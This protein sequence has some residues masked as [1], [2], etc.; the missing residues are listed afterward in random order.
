MTNLI[1][2]GNYLL[3][4]LVFLLSKD[5]LLYGALERS[6]HS[7][8][9]TYR[10][11][12]P[13]RRIY[14]VSDDKSP[15]WRR[16]VYQGY[17]SNRKKNED[18]DW[19]FAF[20][21]Y[22][23][24]KKDIMGTRTKVLVGKGIEGDDWI[25]FCV[26]KTNK[27][28]QSNLIITNDHDMCQHVKMSVDPM[29]IN[30]FSNEMYTGKKVFIPANLPLFEKEMEKYEPDLFDMN[31]NGEFMRLLNGYKETSVVVEVDSLNVLVT[32]IIS[33]DSGD[34]VPSVYRKEIAGGKFRGIGE[35][36]AEKL[37]I[38]YVSE[39][40]EPDPDSEDF[41]ENIADLVCEDKKLPKSAM[42]GIIENV[43]RNMKLVRLE[44]KMF[45]WE[46]LDRMENQW[47]RNQ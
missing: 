8:V 17:K 10:R 44:T 16:D 2:D 14:F 6:L 5:N 1:L 21:V 34:D 25:G 31:D 13:F 36:G 12:Y 3:N 7:T 45:P 26:E 24:F 43:N 28:G 23:Q 11:M 27:M 35:A 38:K 29:W 15:S 9:E 20:G 22:E 4:R 18:I 39:F 32:K 40:G 47:E 19:D 37:Y 42:D 41:A 33:G 30:Y 46:I